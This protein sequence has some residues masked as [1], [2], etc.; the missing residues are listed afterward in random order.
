[1]NSNSSADED[2]AYGKRSFVPAKHLADHASGDQRRFSVELSPTRALASAPN[3]REASLDGGSTP[4]GPYHTARQS[5]ISAS[6]PEQPTSMAETPSHIWTDSYLEDER[7]RIRRQT[8]REDRLDGIPATDPPTSQSIAS[9]R[10]R[11]VVPDRSAEPLGGQDTI[12]RRRKPGDYSSVTELS[13]FTSLGE[14]APSTQSTKRPLPN[15]PTS[16]LQPTDT[17]RRRHHLRERSRR[18]EMGPQSQSGK[19]DS[20]NQRGRD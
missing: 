14:S 2:A 7:S 20:K 12:S 3:T 11:R 15:S 13:V 5:T 6:S 10:T 17:A 8:H 1:M 4:S 18:E 16:A 19:K 9:H